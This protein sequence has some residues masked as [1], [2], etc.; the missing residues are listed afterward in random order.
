[1]RAK[2]FI[3][4]QK[5]GKLSQ[6]HQ[7]STKGLHVFANSNYDRTYDL[8]RV[9]M[10]VASTDG[11]FVPDMD[12]ESWAG[13]FNTAHAYTEVESD[14]LK[15]AYKAA[16]IKYK[17]LNNLVNISDIDKEIFLLQKNLFDLRIK[18]STNQTNKPHLFTHTKRRIAQLKYKKSLLTKLK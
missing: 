18:R 16:G 10:A 3:K 6:R 7:Q 4:E 15:Q 17:D 14:M 2:E 8:N 11:T 13:K 5:V 9:M 12:G 1:M